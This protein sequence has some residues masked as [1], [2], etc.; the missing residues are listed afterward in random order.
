MDQEKPLRP[1]SSKIVYQNP[2]ITVREDVTKDLGGHEGIYGVMESNNSV[3]VVAT[4]EDNEIYLIRK[5]DYPSQAWNWELPGG[6]GDKQDIIVA[7]KRELFEE[8]G[9]DAK[10]LVVLGKTR[11]CNGLMTEQ[12]STVLAR[13]LVFKE[14]PAQT[15]DIDSITGGKFFTV[16]Q[17]HELIKRGEIDDNQTI[18]GIYLAELYK[19]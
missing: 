18:T 10:D 9:I 8:T 13:N 4:N 3:M 15:D 5:F 19:K 6:G 2:W 11:A 16:N 12:I 17:I 14:R 1:I 7:A